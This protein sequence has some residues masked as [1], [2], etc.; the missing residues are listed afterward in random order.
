MSRVEAFL[1]WLLPEDEQD[2]ED[3]D[4]AFLLE[5]GGRYKYVSIIDGETARCRCDLCGAQRALRDFPE[6][7][8][9]VAGHD[10]QGAAEIDPFEE[11]EIVATS[12]YSDIIE[13]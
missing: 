12:E 6:L 13:K 7:V 2:V 3:V 10:E 5:H 9:H 1:D 8:E 11:P 4:T